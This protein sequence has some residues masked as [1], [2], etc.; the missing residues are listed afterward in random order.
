[1]NAWQLILSAL[2]TFGLAVED[3]LEIL[4]QLSA[5]SVLAYVSDKCRIFG[6]WIDWEEFC[7]YLDKYVLNYILV[8]K[9]QSQGSV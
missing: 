5:E 9:A 8:A 7:L 6:K 3:K 1:M 4:S 2:D